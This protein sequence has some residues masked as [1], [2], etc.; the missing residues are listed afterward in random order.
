MTYI[1]VA[2]VYKYAKGFTW[3]GSKYVL[4]NDTSTSFWNISDNTNKTSLNN[5]HYTCWNEVGEC[6]ILS[7]IDNITPYYINL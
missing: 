4:D 3:D 2:N 5:T 7:Y 6:T 1:K